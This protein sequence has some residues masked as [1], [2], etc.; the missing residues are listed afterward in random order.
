MTAEQG[1]PAEASD[2]VVV[3][4]TRFRK[5][6]AKRLRQSHAEKPPVTVHR[7][8]P[9]GALLE[10]LEAR[11][12]AMDASPRS[13]LTAALVLLVARTLREDPR[14]SARREEE[15]LRRYPT[16]N[17]AV[18]MATPN[19]LV[20][21]TI[22]DPE[23]LGLDGIANKVVDLAEAA[24]GGRLSPDDLADATFTITSLGRWGV[25]YFTPIINP[26]QIAILGVGA[27]ATELRL[28][29]GA[30]AEESRLPLS[31]TFDHAEVDGVDGAEF[32]VRLAE[33][34]AGP[35]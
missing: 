29:S 33:H 32:L 27:L 19:G 20:A 6:A 4:E 14:L 11:A 2:Y 9:A 26:P 3:R 30:V 7:S 1:T 12:K 18:A 23:S 13:L 35:A 28:V 16:P 34:V 5:V 8:I 24:R 25:E 21:P 10:W 31:L 22:R 15:E 17:I